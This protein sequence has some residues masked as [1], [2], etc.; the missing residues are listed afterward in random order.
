ML[1]NVDCYFVAK[2]QNIF[3]ESKFQQGRKGDSLGDRKGYRALARTYPK[4]SFC[5]LMTRHK[6]SQV[7]YAFIYHHIVCAMYGYGYR[8]QRR[9]LTV[10]NTTTQISNYLIKDI[11]FLLLFVSSFST[12]TVT[13]QSEH[14]QSIQSLFL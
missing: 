14:Y 1:D 3:P 12:N 5:R 10:C 13:L 6:I 9:F 11:K 8:I 7:Q 4:P 2:V